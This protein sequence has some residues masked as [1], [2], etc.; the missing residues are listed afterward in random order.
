MT[1]VPDRRTLV[2]LVSLVAAMTL[3]SG[4]LLVLEPTAP[5]RPRFGMALQNVHEQASGD[6]Q[7]FDTEAPVEPGRWQAIVIHDSGTLIGSAATID[8]AHKRLG[9]GGLGYHFVI[10]GSGKNDG[11]IERSPRWRLQNSG[12]HSAGDRSDWFNEHAIGVCLIGDLSRQPVSATQMEQLVWLV[13]RL[14]SRL[15]IPAG[16]VYLPTDAGGLQTDSNR[17]LVERLRAQLL[18]QQ[19]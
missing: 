12:A 17:L 10:N 6:V 15:K 2:V 19:P 13:Q 7:L 9:R 3:A 11:Q 5:G 8:R 4:L 1:L 14:Q 16:H 18:T